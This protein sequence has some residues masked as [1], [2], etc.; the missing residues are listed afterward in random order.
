MMASSETVGSALVSFAGL[1]G[2]SE[3]YNSRIS[4]VDGASDLTLLVTHT[5]NSPPAGPAAALI[6]RPVAFHFSLPPRG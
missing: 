3:G 5:A 6:V 4:S 2:S 1:F